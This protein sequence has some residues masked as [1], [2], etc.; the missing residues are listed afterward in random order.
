MWTRRSPKTSKK[1]AIVNFSV[2][3]KRVANWIGFNICWRTASSNAY[4]NQ[5]LLLPIEFLLLLDQRKFSAALQVQGKP[6][7]QD[8]LWGC[9]ITISRIIWPPSYLLQDMKDQTHEFVADNL[10]HLI[11]VIHRDYSAMSETET[12]HRIL[13]DCYRIVMLCFCATPPQT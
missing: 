3:G 12:R 9:L 4:S 7:Y 11:N 10:Q 2:N 1:L 8:L 5:S 6:N 13:T